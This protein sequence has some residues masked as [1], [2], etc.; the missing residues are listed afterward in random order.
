MKL[1][2]WLPDWLVARNMQSYNDKPPMP[3]DE[4]VRG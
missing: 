4:V 1:T 2:R 3:T